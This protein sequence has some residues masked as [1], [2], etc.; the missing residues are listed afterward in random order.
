MHHDG[1]FMYVA[2]STKRK[3]H[4]N[5]FGNNLW[6]DFFQLFYAIRPIPNRKKVR[7]WRSK[8][9]SMAFGSGALVLHVHSLNHDGAHF[10]HLLAH[11]NVPVDKPS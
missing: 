11:F 6:P 3:S 5:T 7:A 4:F 8:I 10:K 2:A 9:L 1:R